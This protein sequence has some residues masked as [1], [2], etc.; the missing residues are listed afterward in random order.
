[1]PGTI[2]SNSKWPRQ[3]GFQYFMSKKDF[4]PTNP[5]NLKAVWEARQK[6]ALK[7]KRE[8]EMLAE[9][10]KEQEYLNN[11]ALLGDEKAR[12]GL[13]FMY[14]PPAGVRKEGDDDLGKKTGPV[15]DWQRKY[16]APRDEWDKDKKLRDNPFGIDVRYIFCLRCKKW[17]HFHFDNDCPLYN[18]SGTPDNPG[19]S[20]NPS[21]IIKMLNKE[22]ETMK[23]TAG[24]SK[25]IVSK[26]E[27]SK[28]FLEKPNQNNEDT[29]DEYEEKPEPIILKRLLQGMSE[30]HQLKFK[31]NILNRIKDD[32]RFIKLSTVLLKPESNGLNKIKLEVES[33]IENPDEEIM[34]TF[35]EMDE[36]KRNQIL[37]SSFFDTFPKDS[38]KYFKDFN[39]ELE[40]VLRKKLLNGKPKVN[41][42]KKHKK[43]HK[44]NVTS[45]KK[46][47]KK[48]RTR[49]NS[50]SSE[51][52]SNPF[53]KKIKGEII[54]FDFNF[55]SYACEPSEDEE[56]EEK[57][58]GC[59]SAQLEEELLKSFMNMDEDDRKDVIGIR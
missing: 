13:S 55:N 7:E 48:L 47:S 2:G 56:E 45:S 11:K 25:Q 14:N 39:I 24:P 32:E 17:G 37:E 42:S 58:N 54:D 16:N 30:E 18:M 57:F 44:K 27:K 10:E 20:N 43:M 8:A 6:K 21:D 1:M 35:Q 29:N 12:L 50:Y 51:S 15:F 26:L 36:T 46:K 59:S 5:K 9:Y 40:S 28:N 52:D 53:S 38:R 23:N 33:D 4:H 41:K 31:K 49:Y 3:K 19:Y 22:R 34:K